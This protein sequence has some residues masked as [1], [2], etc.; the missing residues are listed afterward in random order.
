M[1]ELDINYQRM[2]WELMTRLFPIH[3]SILGPGYKESLKIIKEYLPIKTLEYKTG[4]KCGSWKIP[5]EWNLTEAYIEDMN[6]KK[7]INYSESSNLQV[8]QRSIAFKGIVSKNELFKHLYWKEDIDDDAIPASISYYKPNWGFSVSKRQMRKL[9][10]D[11]FKVVI[12]SNFYDGF[13]RIGEFLIEGDSSKEII[14][15]SY[16]CHPS[17]ANDNLSGVV[18]AVALMDLIYKM[19]QRKYSY[20]L[21]LTPETIGPI[22]YFHQNPNF[23]KNVIGGITLVCVGDSN[24]NYY[25]RKSRPGDTLVDK[26]V[27]HSLRHSGYNFTVENFS[28]ST[29]T[30]GNEK[31]YNSLGIEIPVSSFR[32][33]TIGSYKEHL[34]SKD[35]LDFVKKECLFDSLKILY[36]AILAIENEAI[37]KHTYIGE[38]FLTGLGIY[39]EVKKAEDRIAWDFIIAFSDGKN[40]LIDIAEKAGI[41]IDKFFIP[42][43][44][45]TEKKQ[46]VKI[47]TNKD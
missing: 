40:S 32:R 31:A 25:F 5:K 28:V 7:L 2:M 41:F 23:K 11:K 10:G 34:T 24:P 12:K 38:P 20:R 6:G 15:D 3:R 9:N 35:D 8:C 33:S 21:I 13:L 36:N 39:P 26:A 46:L 37:Y 43:K 30:S 45:L 16:L 22:V 18:V 44:K 14:I 27:L 29:G 47:N 19:S 17:L 4:T 42:I 1:F